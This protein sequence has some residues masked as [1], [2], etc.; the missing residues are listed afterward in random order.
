[1]PLINELLEKAENVVVR[2]DKFFVR[3][4]SSSRYRPSDHLSNMFNQVITFINGIQDKPIPIQ[5]CVG[6][7]AG[8]QVFSIYLIKFVNI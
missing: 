1:M 3:S 4:S 6:S 7:T 2:K 8:W 5:I